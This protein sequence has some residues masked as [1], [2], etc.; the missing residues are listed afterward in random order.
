MKKLRPAFVP[1]PGFVIAAID[2]SQ[3][4]L[5]VA[6]QI[7][8]SAPM[9][10]AFLDGK[11]L[12]RELAATINMIA[13]EDVTDLQRTQAKA[14]NFGLLYM[15]GAAGFREYAETVYGVSLTDKEAVRVYRAFFAQWEGMRE[16]HQQTIAKIH[17]DGYI[18]SPIGRVRRLPD[19][20][21]GVDKW[22]QSA[23][24]AGVNSPVQGLGADLMNMAT[25]SIMGILPGTQAV[26]GAY[27][28]NT[29]H[30][31]V[32]VEVEESRWEEIVAECQ[33]R[34]T[35]LNPYLRKMGF[36]MDMPLKADATVGTRWSLDD[37]GT[38]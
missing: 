20:F 32:T 24:R 30:D 13:P 4:E 21:S 16:W 33:E 36:E 11:D 1:R 31:E 17:R 28:V 27:P 7:S 35:N 9:I 38:M 10:Q 8:R 12:H 37:V 3:L 5:R 26:R 29:V 22:V 23:E 25:A 19:V 34:M 6:A 15:M 14:G 2:H 18:T